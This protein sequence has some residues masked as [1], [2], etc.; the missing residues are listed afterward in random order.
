MEIQEK[1]HGQTEKIIPTGHL[2]LLTPQVIY[3]SLQVVELSWQHHLVMTLL[4]LV[5][6]VS[7]ECSMQ[8]HPLFMVFLMLELTVKQSAEDLLFLL[9]TSS[10]DG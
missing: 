3:K 4:S 6:Q 5:I 2:K 9:V 1:Y 8:D 7:A 10:M